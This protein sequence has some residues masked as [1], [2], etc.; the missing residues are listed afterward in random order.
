MNFLAP[1]GLFFGLLIPAVILLYLLKLKRM[2]ITIS[3][4]LLWRK[5]LEDLKA[6]T[7]FQKLKRNLLLFIQ[8]AIIA[9]LTFAAAR[10]VLELGGLH[11]QS[12]IVLI[13]NSASMSA[14]DVE[15]NRLEAA[16]KKAID[17][18]NDMSRGDKMM[19]V[20]FA[21]GA[22]VLS[23]FEQDKATL[24][25]VI[26]AIPATDAQTRIEEA[27]RIAK[28]AANTSSNPEIILFSDGGFRIPSQSPLA[29]LK[30]RYVPVGRNSNN[31]GLTDLVVRKDFALQQ[32]YQ[33]LAGLQNFS[34]EEKEVFVELYGE[35]EVVNASPA[36]GANGA[37]PAAE[38][39]PAPKVERKLMDARKITLAA[40][41]A[42]TILFKD[43]G[44]FPEK[45]EVILDSADALK[46]DNRAWAIIPREENIHILLLTNGNPYLQRV[47]NLDPRVRLSAAPPGGGAALDQYDVVVFDSNAPAALTNGN[48][49][50]INAIPPLPEWTRGE[51]TAYPPL[52]DWNRF[53]PLTRHVN[54]DN[55]IISKCR[56]MGTPSWVDIIAESRQTALIAAFQ[57]EK[58]KGLVAAFDLYDSN[59]PLRVSYPIF[60]SNLL[61]WF[62]T[63]KGPSSLMKRTSDII[64][65]E[66]PDIPIQQASFVPPPPLAPRPL[67]FAGGAP[68]YFG[69]TDKAGIYQFMIN[70]R[71]QS[72]YAVNL[73]SPE[74]SSIEPKVSLQL[75]EGEEIEGEAAATQSNQEIWRWL[76]ILGLLAIFLEW[77]VY[78]NRARYAF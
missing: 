23:P 74:E 12:F 70:D 36:I 11:G 18:V 57:Q 61:N 20:S 1:L 21:N 14:T 28:T 5:T 29:S 63:D 50:F 78:V 19:V 56:N 65:L 59:W 32:N 67:A 16:K 7:P 72:Q 75:E 53:H 46:T 33:L 15:P 38:S 6:N 4:T 68:V 48:Y 55:L 51:E 2:D 60:F 71:L 69:D 34:S 76:A 8:L 64:A 31:V 40:G 24:R 39:T 45:I 3:S 30:T 13:D 43:E 25:S 35:G 58:I 42:E 66:A 77:Y 47:L 41:K 73:L 27:A 9:L 17:L 52:V 22:Q 49:I 54:L 44:Y 26:R 37:N 62:I 10:P